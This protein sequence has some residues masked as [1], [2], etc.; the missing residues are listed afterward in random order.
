MAEFEET[1]VRRGEGPAVS[2]S[3]SLHR[4][5]VEEVRRRVGKRAFSSYLEEALL[6]QMQREDLREI[7][8]DHVAEFGEFTAAELADARAAL[9]G[10][11]E[12]MR[13]QAA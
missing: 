4:G 5:T 13:G 3:A 9:Y 1:T 7:V 12:Q 8:D 10:A 11:E 2:I 6:L